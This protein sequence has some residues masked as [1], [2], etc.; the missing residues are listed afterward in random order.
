MLMLLGATAAF[1]I[2][3]LRIDGLVA[4]TFTPFLPNGTINPDM[5][6]EQA[7][8]L[9]STGVSWVFVSGTTGES[10][11]LTFAERKAQ[12]ELWVQI[13]PKYNISVIVH[14]GTESIF[15]AVELAKHAQSIGAAAIGA[16]PPV[17]FKP[18]SPGSLAM[19]MSA[20]FAAAP[21]LPAYYYHIPS[22]TGVDFAM[23]DFI[24][25]M[26]KLNTAPNFVGVKYTGL[27]TYPGFMDVTRIINYKNGKY[28][29]LC[30]REDMMLE[31]LAAGLTGFVGSQFNFA[32]DL[33]NHIRSVFQ[34]NDLGTIRKL[35]YAAVSLIGAWQ[36][37]VSAGVDGC[38]NVLNVMGKV[39][40]GD[41]RLPSIPIS[42]LD[43][44]TLKAAV[45]DIC[46]M[47]V[48][49]PLHLRICTTSGKALSN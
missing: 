10:V 21:S 5:V 23:M 44:V 8:W 43:E 31:A 16:M 6:A 4:A 39:N 28:E 27:Y 12:A 35:Q 3:P 11:K 45:T 46:R 33:F 34:A 37:G 20:I 14:V 32:G 15:E 42:A 48:I 36:K 40:V 25:A 17:F 1:K 49:D 24:E 30:G 38:K 29:V 18:S 26:E 19:T 22:M 47:A 7:K 9:Q 41:A 2:S 13:A